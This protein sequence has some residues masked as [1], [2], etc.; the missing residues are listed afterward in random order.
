MQQAYRDLCINAASEA[1][2]NWDLPMPFKTLR[3]KE[4]GWHL[5]GNIF[6]YISLKDS[7][8]TLLQISLNLVPRGRSDDNLALTEVFAWHERYD[9]ALPESE[10][11]RWCKYASIDLC[12]LKN[13]C[14]R[15][16]ANKDISVEIHRELLLQLNKFSLKHSQD[17][18]VSVRKT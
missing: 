4:N 13:K 15:H 2:N 9:K 6:E 16:L 3:P 7:F 14:I 17:W 5:I 18:W 1:H 8:C 10:V 11:I 12:E